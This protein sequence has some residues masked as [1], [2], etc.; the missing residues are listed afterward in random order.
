MTLPAAK[1]AVAAMRQKA[2]ERFGDGVRV[3]GADSL[4]AWADAIEPALSLPDAG[5]VAWLRYRPDGTPDWAEDCIA[6]DDHFLDADLEREGYTLRPLFDHPAPASA[7][8]D[9]AMVERALDAF[10]EAARQTSPTTMPDPSASWVKPLMHAAL[11]AALAR[12]TP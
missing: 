12:V 11:A 1:N 7:E 9:E 3:V 4:R 8:V 2:D 10:N 6:Q 5:A